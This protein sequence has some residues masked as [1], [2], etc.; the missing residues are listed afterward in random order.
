MA[1][2]RIR[3]AVKDAIQKRI[4]R[5]AAKDDSDVIVIKPKRETGARRRKLKGV[6]KSV[7]STVAAQ[8]VRT[9]EKSRVSEKVI[10][11]LGELRKALEVFNAELKLQKFKV[12]EFQPKV[13]FSVDKGHFTVK[14]AESPRELEDALRLRF[15]VFH[16]E[17][18]K[19]SRTFGVDVDGL[20]F[21]CDHLIIRDNR[22]GE[23]VGT[24]RFNSST[25]STTFYSTSEFVLDRVLAL[26]G[27]KL[28]MGRAAI[29]KEY[30]TGAIISLLWR[31]LAEYM[32]LTQTRYLFGCSSVKTV[33]PLQIGLVTHYLDQ[34]GAINRDY[35][36]EPTKKFKIKTLRQALEYIE[37]NPYEYDESTVEKQIPTLLASY[38]KAGSMVLGEPAIDNDFN[39]IDFLTLL[40]VENMNPAYKKKFLSPEAEA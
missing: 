3:R 34:I 11:R 6:T 4:G 14:T 12:R 39:C 5:A 15:T 32:R 13:K 22:S 38:I 1:K 27:H 33:D 26:P 29:K 19:K 9:A 31:G 16:K 2:G 25:Y 35:G 30:R 20:D 36:V 7:A 21:V 24:Y 8:V 23:V 10:Q 40:D 28:E 18:M 37:Q 17:Y